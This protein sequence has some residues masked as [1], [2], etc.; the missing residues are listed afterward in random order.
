MTRTA[1]TSF[2]HAPDAAGGR[3]EGQR[4]GARRRG[5]RELRLGYI[6]SVASGSGSL[7]PSARRSRRRHVAAAEMRSSIGSG[8]RH[9]AKTSSGR[10]ESDAR[11]SRARRRTRG[12]P[13]R[14]NDA[15]AA[16][17]AAAT[18]VR[19][20]KPGKPSATNARS[21]SGVAFAGTFSAI[22][23]AAR[24]S[25]S[26]TH[27]ARSPTRRVPLRSSSASSSPLVLV[28]SDESSRWRSAAASSA[29]MSAARGSGGRA[30]RSGEASAPPSAFA[31]SRSA[32]GCVGARGSRCARVETG[33]SRRCASC[34]SGAFALMLSTN[35]DACRSGSGAR[36]GSRHAMGR[37]STRASRCAR[38]AGRSTRTRCVGS[39]RSDRASAART[40]VAPCFAA[41]D[42]HT[43][44]AR[45]DIRPEG[46]RPETSAYTCPSRASIPPPRWSAVRSGGCQ[47][48]P[49]G[50]STTGAKFC[51]C[52][53]RAR[54]VV[55]R[56]RG[57]RGGGNL[58]ASRGPLDAPR[59]RD[60]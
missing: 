15:A 7:A 53:L 56:V 57:S 12:R 1:R 49:D 45:L 35:H 42:V 38:D 19:P 48:F 2:E 59:R 30:A 3:R 37:R 5:A 16:A 33:P 39:A 8:A 13:S 10:S 47:D 21:S 25:S 51:Q 32:R 11:E 60:F 28:G 26:E 6:E 34:G 40:I 50:V 17:A 14:S 44:S 27:P 43:R 31:R 55:D 20:T 58:S 52:A 22:E 24:A 23:R 18:W 36:F 46:P 9:L 41:N 4:A 54:G 29:S